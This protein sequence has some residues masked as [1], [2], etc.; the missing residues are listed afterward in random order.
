M[1]GPDLSTGGIKNEFDAINQ[2]LG[3]DDLRP[4]ADQQASNL[5]QSAANIRQLFSEYQQPE[6]RGVMSYLPA[7]ATGLGALIDLLSGDD[8]RIAGIGPKTEAITAKVQAQRDKKSQEKRQKLLDALGIESTTANLGNEAYRTR[9][10]ARGESNQNKRSVLN[11]TQQIMGSRQSAFNAGEEIKLRREMFKS[12]EDWKEYQKQRNAQA[13]AAAQAEQDMSPQAVVSGIFQEEMSNATELYK[14]LLKNSVDPAERQKIFDEI[15]SVAERRT[16]KRLG[17]SVEQL[18]AQL[19]GEQITDV[20]EDNPADFAPAEEPTQDVMGSLLGNQEGPIRLGERGDDILNALAGILP[21]SMD[22][23]P[24]NRLMK[25][26]IE[27]QRLA[28]WHTKV[29][30]KYEIVG[31]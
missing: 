12:D 21:Q 26:R 23:S 17:I 4:M 10:G 19:G 30:K 27:K 15:D 5:N 1:A 3:L 2:I 16:A 6:K 13:D 11:D 9:A 8:D 14:D 18:R 31:Q 22:W 28:K 7:A 25:E 29:K 24:L 20:M